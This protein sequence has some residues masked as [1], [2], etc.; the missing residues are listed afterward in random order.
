MDPKFDTQ[1]IFYR[2]KPRKPITVQI[3]NKNMVQDEFMG[4]VILAASTNDPSTTQ[5]LQLRKKGRAKADEMPGFITL[6]TITC[7]NLTDL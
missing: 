7:E 3:W 2:K 1:A 6:R 5:R 4:Q